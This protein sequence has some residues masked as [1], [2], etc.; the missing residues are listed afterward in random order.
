MEW[1]AVGCDVN[2]DVNS[3]VNCDVGKAVRIFLQ[4]KGRQ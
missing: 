1:D 4:K 3:D 2:N